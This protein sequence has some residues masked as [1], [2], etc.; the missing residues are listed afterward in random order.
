MKFLCPNCKAKYQI[1]PEKLVGRRIAKIRCRKC[2]YRIQIAPRAGSE[3]YDITASANSL[4]PTGGAGASLAPAAAAASI[5]PMPPAPAV[6]A[7]PAPPPAPVPAP[8]PAAAAPRIPMPGTP[9]ARAAAAPK[10]RA[11]DK[12]D[13]ST[14]AGSRKPTA[15]VPGLPGLGASKL[16]RST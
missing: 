13:S 16:T 9:G 14:A 3:E 8:K 6:A 4:A 2:D 7:V 10:A 1:G 11:A 5:A 15:A 12:D